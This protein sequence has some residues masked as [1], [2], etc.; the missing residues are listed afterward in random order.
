MCLCAV[1]TSYAGFAYLLAAFER[2]Q[3]TPQNALCPI[4]GRAIRV[5]IKSRLPEELTPNLITNSQDSVETRRFTRLKPRVSCHAASYRVW[6]VV[7]GVRG[8]IS[9]HSFVTFFQNFYCRRSPSPHERDSYGLL[10]TNQVCFPT[11][12]SLAARRACGSSEQMVW[13]LEMAVSSVRSP[14]HLTADEMQRI[15]WVGTYIGAWD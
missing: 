15:R 12:F 8:R 10:E 9:T 14:A 4:P 7:A 13:V 1:T 5:T 11:G 3:A 2:Q 6:Y